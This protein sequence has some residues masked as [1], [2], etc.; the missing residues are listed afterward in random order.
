MRR[1]LSLGAEADVQTTDGKN[2]KI[3]SLGEENHGPVALW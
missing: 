3:P 2:R 1:N